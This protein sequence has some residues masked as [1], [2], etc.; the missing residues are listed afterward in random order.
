MLRDKTLQP[1]LTLWSGQALS[2]LGSQIVQFGI[3]WW[4][5][6]QTGSATVL[7][8]ASLVGLLPQ[9]ILG[10][11]I[12]VWVDR[13]NRRLILFAADVAVALAT[14]GLMALFALEVVAIWHIFVLLFVRAIAGAFHW[15]TMSAS[16]TLMVPEERLTQIQGLNQMLNGGL[17][18]VSA[19]LGALF[20]TLLPMTGLLLIDVITAVFAIAPLFFI[21]IPQ[22]PAQLKEQNE[23]ASTFMTD[24]KDGLRYIWG[25]PGMLFLMGMA[26]FANLVMTPA[27]SLLPLLVSDHFQETAYFL[28]LINV[29]FGIGIIVGGLTL[30]SWGGFRRKIVTSLLG[31]MGIGIGMFL[32]GIVPAEG[33]VF[34][35]IVAAAIVGLMMPI[36]NGPIQ[37][38]MQSTIAPEM[39]GRI[40]ALIGSLSQAMAP[41]GL[42]IAG[43]IADQFSVPIFFMVAGIGTLLMGVSGFLIPP[44][45]NIEEKGDVVSAALLATSQSSET[46]LQNPT[47][48]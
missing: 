48:V 17:N 13:L 15:S 9:V 40:F 23:E 25:W 12:G 46:E 32:M 28:S 42:L 7:A 45:F 44:V 24:F 2:L 41:L 5:T 19:P 21:K 4:L 34:W 20:L 6:Q 39:Q 10:P 31:L 43:P 16:T 29:T 27:I 30:A 18:I 1:F 33:P 11:F 47:L 3:I 37:A 26:M 8:T 36:T 38:I 14:V 35:V 22:P